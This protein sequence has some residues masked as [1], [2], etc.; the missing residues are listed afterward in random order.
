[1]DRLQPTPSSRIFSGYR[2]RW[3]C[4]GPWQSL[5]RMLAPSLDRHELQTNTAYGSSFCSSFFHLFWF[6]NCI[7]AVVFSFF[8]FFLCVCRSIIVWE[9]TRV[10]QVFLI[11]G[12][13]GVALLTSIGHTIEVCVNEWLSPRPH[14]PTSTCEGFRWASMCWMFWAP[15]NLLS[16]CLRFVRFQTSELVR[17]RL[18]HDV[19]G[20]KVSRPCGP[21]I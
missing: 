1:M 10:A 13:I 6:C 14:R 18:I 2:A 15:A 12:W 16:V 7:L 19:G 20:Q 21:N 8:W 17:K 5:Q 3:S 9:H 4:C 11:Y